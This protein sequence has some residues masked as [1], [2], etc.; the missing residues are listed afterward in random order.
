M[1][2]LRSE[3]EDTRQWHLA[4]TNEQE[5][6]SSGQVASGRSVRH[7][8]ALTTHA[9]SIHKDLEARVTSSHILN[10]SCSIINKSLAKVRW[11]DVLDEQP[12]RM[13]QWPNEHLEVLNEHQHAITLT[14]AHVCDATRGSSISCTV[15]QH[16]TPKVGDTYG[17]GGRLNSLAWRSAGQCA[18]A[19][20][21]RCQQLVVLVVH[22][23]RPKS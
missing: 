19:A 22:K 12:C 1:Q 17:Q 4:S 11:W 14:M 23:W 16:Y 20:T 3:G 2:D 6:Q 15:P 5:Q 18:M 8:H 13:Y 10:V 21:W 9:F 7:L